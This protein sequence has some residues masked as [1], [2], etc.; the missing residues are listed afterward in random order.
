MIAVG[1]DEPNLAAGPKTFI[2]EFQCTDSP[3]W[4]RVDSLKEVTSPVHDLSFA[5]CL[6][7]SFH[8]LGIASRDVLI[9]K[10]KPLP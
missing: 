5:P 8:V 3:Q 6:G 2:Y 1:S 10:I 9:V 4:V 7:R